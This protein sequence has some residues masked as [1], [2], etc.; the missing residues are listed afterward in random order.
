[1]HTRLFFGM[2]PRIP[3]LLL[4]RRARHWARQDEVKGLWG[5]RLMLRVWQLFGRRAFTLLLWPVIGVYWLT[6][7]PARQAS[8][9]WIKRVKTTLAQRNL[10]VPPRLNSFFHFMRFG[11]AMLNKVASWRGELKLNRDVVLPLAR[12]KRSIWMRRRAN[13][14]WPRILAMLKPVGRWPSLKAVKSSMPWYSAITPNAL[15]KS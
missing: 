5:M 4:R 11:N 6:A 12:A 9:Q 13:C 15:S 10:P 8:Q 2:L 7:H 3:A 14:C 1:M